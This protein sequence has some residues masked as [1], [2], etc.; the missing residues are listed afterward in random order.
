MHYSEQELNKLIETVEK[1][2]SAHLAKA[3]ADDSTLAK[4]EVPTEQAI[5]K[6][7][8]VAAEPVQKTEEKEAH[9][10]HEEQKENEPKHEEGHGY[11]SEDMEHMHKMYGSMSKGELKA[12]HESVRGALEKC[13]MAKTEEIPMAKTEEKAIEI[14]AE[15]KT[16]TETLIKS[17]NEKLKEE[18]AELKKN[19]EGVSQFLAKFVEK[20]A[21][22]AA[23]AITSLDVIAKSEETVGSGEAKTLSKSEV[24]SILLRKTADPTLSKADRN[25]IDNFYL[26]KASIETISHLLK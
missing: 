16:E 10:E 3:E 20:T 25:A 15:V 11:D 6:V 26:N 24:T 4:S 19:F 23:K 1:E 17:E 14:P 7:E 21:A 9:S 18:L 12:H 8:E 2:F 22:P 5:S 13:G